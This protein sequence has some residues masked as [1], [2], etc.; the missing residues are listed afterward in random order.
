MTNELDYTFRAMGSD[1][2][3]LIGA[4]PG[5][6]FSAAAGR[7]RPRARVRVEL[8]RSAVQVSAR[9]RPVVAEPRPARPRS[10]P[11]PAAS[12]GQRRRVG[13][14]AQWRPRRSDARR[15]R[16]SGAGTAVRSTVWN[17]PR[18]PTHSRMPRRD[19]PR[20][21]T[22]PRV[23]ALVAVD[24]QAGT[25]TRPPGLMIDTGGTG[26][27]LCADA[28]ALRLASYTRFVVDC[29]GDI[30]IGGIGAQLKPYDDR[31]E[32]PLTGEPIGSI[33]VASWRD[34]D[35]RPQRPHLAPRR[36]QL[37][38]PSA[39]PEHRIAGLEWSGRRDRARRHARSRPRRCRR[40]RC[41]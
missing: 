17:Q 34:R 29:G 19:G 36:R 41:C 28:V 10:C 18:S 15:E 6:R 33:K 13:R 35:V 39:G 5:A 30:A 1:V 32:H 27:G 2:R 22:R 8:Q 37:R 31:V 4:A 25:I 24:D 12:G 20:S 11:A 14:R 26:K 16:S 7:G 21:R 38:A 23:G 40:W 9:Q 3:L